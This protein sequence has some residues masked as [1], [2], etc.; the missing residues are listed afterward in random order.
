MIRF[1]ADYLK[2]LHSATDYP[3]FEIEKTIEQF[4]IWEHNKHENIMT[5]RDQSHTS[6]LTNHVSPSHHTKWMDA[7]DD[8]MK[9]YMQVPE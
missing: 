8:S 2:D 1:Q 5:F 6:V 7:K 4:M 9:C 3:P